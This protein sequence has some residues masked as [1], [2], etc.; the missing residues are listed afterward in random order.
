MEHHMA[1]GVTGAEGDAKLNSVKFDAIAIFE[2]AIRTD[3]FAAF[4]AIFFSNFLRFGRARKFLPFA[5]LR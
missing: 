5:G 2:P 1:G 4:P 3:I